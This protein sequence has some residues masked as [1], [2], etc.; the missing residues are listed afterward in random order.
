MK[1]A[2]LI[3]ILALVSTARADMLVQ[4]GDAYL[5]SG[6]VAWNN[7]SGWYGQG[8]DRFPGVNPPWNPVSLPNSG[9]RC[10]ARCAAMEPIEEP[11]VVVQPPPQ[12]APPKTYTFYVAGESVTVNAAK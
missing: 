8:W 4:F 5:W 9:V 10:N 1:F 6:G 2:S 11:V 7:G 3:G 12:P